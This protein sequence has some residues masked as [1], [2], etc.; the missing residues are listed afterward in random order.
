MRPAFRHVNLTRAATRLGVV[1]HVTPHLRCSVRSVRSYNSDHNKNNNNNSPLDTLAQGFQAVK[2]T[3][4]NKTPLRHVTKPTVETLPFTGEAS[5]WHDAVREAQGLVH[6]GDEDR[7]MDPVKLLG[8]D[9]WELKDNIKRLLGSGHPFIKT[10]VKHY[11]ASDTE[12]IRPL[13]VQLVAQ[14]TGNGII[15]PE[16]R[17]LGE[18]SE[19][20][21]IAS[22]LHYDVLD[23]NAPTHVFGNKMAVLAGDF[24]LARASL[25]LA[26]LRTAECIELMATCI[27]NLV[28]GEVMLVKKQSEFTVDDYLQQCYLKTASLIGQSCKSSVVLGRQPGTDHHELAQAAYDYGRHFGM[29]LQ[30]SHDIRQF[31]KETGKMDRAPSVCTPLLYAAEEFPELNQIM[32]RQFGHAEDLEKTRLLVYKSQGLKR[33]FDLIHTHQQAAIQVAQQFNSSQS[34]QALIQLAQ[35]VSS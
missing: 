33:T 15:K 34:Q 27:A 1:R 26:Q 12:R 14:A 19:M 22:L 5:N 13:L 31:A 25:A 29:A 35:H 20:I 32:E 9:V 30:L 4:V 23:D 10:L 7:M 18:I 2:A 8:E 17:R 28:E 3:L 6:T 24:L 21:Y 11:L 16:Q